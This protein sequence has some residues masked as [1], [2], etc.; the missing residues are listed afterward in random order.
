MNYLKLVRL[1]I[2]NV[3]EG[4]LKT[5]RNSY[6]R[7]VE[8]LTDVE[9][10]T[11]DIVETANDI[12]IK[13]QVIDDDPLFRL[14]MG[15]ANRFFIASLVSCSRANQHQKDNVAWQT[16][17]HYYAAYYAIHYL[18]RT[19]GVCLT[20]LD[21]AAVDLI[22]RRQLISPRVAKLSGGLYVLRYDEPNRTL[23]LTKNLK[24]GQG[25]SHKDTWQLWTELIARL[26]STASIDIAE[27]IVESVE[28][29]SHKQFL[30]R[31]T[32]RFNPP[33]LRGEVNYQFK[34]GAWVFEKSSHKSITRLQASINDPNLGTL[35]SAANLDALITN[36]KLIINF[37]KQLFEYSSE[38]YPK[39][40]C[41]ALRN[42]YAEYI[43]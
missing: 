3:V 37:A 31:S 22:L 16:V 24:K 4:V 15:E 18:L 28:L 25:G 21:A 17:E 42:K 41:R 32:G 20:N 40:I 6:D 30:E 9:F 10:L 26:Q 2:P 35:S 12:N 43:Q 14:L 34:G 7:L 23:L 27:Y 13:L 38:T 39:G 11:L 33:E 5:Q 1:L 36:N 29:L 8:S 19:T